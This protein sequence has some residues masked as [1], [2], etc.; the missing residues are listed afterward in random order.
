MGSATPLLVF[1]VQLNVAP[2]SPVRAGWPWLWD[3][4]PLRG[5]APPRRRCGAKD[6]KP[7]PFGMKFLIFPNEIVLRVAGVTD[8]PGGA[9]RYCLGWPAPRC[10]KVTAGARKEP[11][12]GGKGGVTSCRR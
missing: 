10:A 1:S 3:V 5:P 8:R 9:G 12:M 7:I 4:R 6:R 2:R 11:V